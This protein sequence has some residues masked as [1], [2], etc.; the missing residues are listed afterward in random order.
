[1]IKSA[2][3]Y[4]AE[5]IRRLT[6]LDWLLPVLLTS[7]AA[8]DD[9]SGAR[10]RSSL[11]LHLAR[12]LKELQLSKEEFAQVAR[13]CV[14]AMKRLPTEDVA[15]FCHV[16]LLLAAQGEKSLFLKAIIRYFE[17]VE[18]ET[19]TTE[20]GSSPAALELLQAEGTV[21]V[22]MGIAIAR[23]PALVRHLERVIRADLFDE[24]ITPFRLALVLSCAR[25][26]ACSRNIS[27][28]LYVLCKQ[29]VV[30]TCAGNFGAAHRLAIQLPGHDRQPYGRLDTSKIYSA[31]LSVARRSVVGHWDLCREALV[32]TAQMLMDLGSSVQRGIGLVS[33]PPERQAAASL[34]VSLAVHLFAQDR[35]TR[36]PLLQAISGRFISNHDAT[37]QYLE[38][39]SRIVECAPVSASCLLLRFRLFPHLPCGPQVS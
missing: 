33:A 36:L 28:S 37:L 39:L 24:D 13:A 8:S 25:S 35:D 12:S 19:G 6:E 5:I 17:K 21:F 4:Q 10:N 16:C 2:L 9:E 34:G 11:A 23:D 29:I 22:H 20:A 14:K 3:M 26:S 1:M 32:E 15:P 18:S 38:L 7:T 30:E 31:L 27:Q